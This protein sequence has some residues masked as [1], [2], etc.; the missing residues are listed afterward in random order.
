MQ[1]NRFYIFLLLFL[2]GSFV[3]AQQESSIAKSFGQNRFT[4]KA[5]FE[6]KDSVVCFFLRGVAQAK[7]VIGAHSVVVPALI[8]VNGSAFAILTFCGY[9]R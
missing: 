1:M 6:V 7:P 3:N 5:P 9:V 2:A 8:K 4:N